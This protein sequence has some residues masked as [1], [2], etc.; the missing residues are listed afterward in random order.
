MKV[1]TVCS[2]TG[3]T[4]EHT[5]T[6]TAGELDMVNM[7]GLNVVLQVCCLPRLVDPGAHHT[8]NIVSMLPNHTFQQLFI[9]LQA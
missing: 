6:H 4:G 8:L 1:S 7:L 2:K 3:S 9:L 5:T